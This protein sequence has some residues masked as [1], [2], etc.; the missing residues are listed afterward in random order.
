MKKLKI[1]ALNGCI[2]VESFDGKHNEE[3][4]RAKI[5]DSNKNYLDY[6]SLDGIS[7]QQYKDELKTLSSAKD[8]EEFAELLGQFRYDY[9]ESL[10]YLMS[11]I[12]DTPDYSQEEFD[13]MEHDRETMSE[14]DFIQEYMIN[15]VGNTYFYFGDY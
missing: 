7:K 5:Y 15:R 2:Y 6:I 10:E 11:S 4:D 14:S 1:K 12:F 8:F 13:N 9:S 3:E